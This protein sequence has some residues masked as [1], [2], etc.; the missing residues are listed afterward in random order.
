[1]RDTTVL[2]ISKA[3]QAHMY[4]GVSNRLCC[5]VQILVYSKFCMCICIYMQQQEQQQQQQQQRGVEGA[6]G[7]TSILDRASMLNRRPRENEVEL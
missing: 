6:C 5:L 4:I 3:T 1:M 2:R 7:G